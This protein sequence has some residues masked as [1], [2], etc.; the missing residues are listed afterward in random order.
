M[1]L[2]PHPAFLCAAAGAYILDRRRRKRNQT[3]VI[4]EGDPSS[5]RNQHPRHRDRF[6][7]VCPP[8]PMGIPPQGIPPRGI[9][10]VATTPRPPVVT[11][12]PPTIPPPPQ[13]PRPPPGVLTSPRGAPGLTAAGMQT[14]PHGI[15]DF[16]ST[17]RPLQ[18]GAQSDYPNPY[19]SYAAAL[20]PR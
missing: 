11:G 17:R 18:T 10:P 16:G 4:L 3:T 9:P 6:A 5:R 7:S 15:Y 19:S 14:N 13:T 12:I 2:I 1:S 20:K 8:Q